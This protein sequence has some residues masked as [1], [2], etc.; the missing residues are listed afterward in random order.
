MMPTLAS[1]ILGKAVFKKRQDLIDDYTHVRKYY[2]GLRFSRKIS[3]WKF[4]S[5]L[6]T[7]VDTTSPPSSIRGIDDADVIREGHSSSEYLNSEPFH[8]LPNHANLFSEIR[9]Y[10]RFVT[11]I[12]ET[13]VDESLPSID[14]GL[15]PPRKYAFLEVPKV[16]SSSL[17]K[18]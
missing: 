15:T 5:I 17:L 14:Q 13:S 11:Q 12:V 8:H 10:L 1:L 2:Q 9:K 16:T 4:L 18:I 3:D 7:N 6:G